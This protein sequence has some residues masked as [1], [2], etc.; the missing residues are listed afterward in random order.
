MVVHRLLK[1][2]AFGPEEIEIVATAYEDTLA[3]LDLPSGDS[4]VT[5]IVAKKIIEIAQTGEVDPVRISGR[6]I[7][8]LGFPDAA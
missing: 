3:A 6:A 8:E 4:P 2:S 5:E 1:Y 7:V